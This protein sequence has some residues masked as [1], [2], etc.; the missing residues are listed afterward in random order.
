MSDFV[1]EHDHLPGEEL[2][3][4]DIG[5]VEGLVDEIRSKLHDLTTAHEALVQL[6]DIARR[7][8]QNTAENYPSDE[9][10]AEYPFRFDDYVLDLTDAWMCYPHIDATPQAEEDV[11]NFVTMLDGAVDEARDRLKNQEEAHYEYLCEMSE[12]TAAQEREQAAR[13]LLS[14]PVLPPLNGNNPFGGIVPIAASEGTVLYPK[15]KENGE[16]PQ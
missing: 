4:L 11:E 13:E 7:D 12:A 16:R 3:D 15:K 10:R 9:V 6:L 5:T 8:I 14:L 1:T 2:C